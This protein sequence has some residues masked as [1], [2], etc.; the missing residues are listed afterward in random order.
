MLL[1]HYK[2]S[3]KIKALELLAKHNGLLQD[4]PTGNTTVQVMIGIA[5]P[6]TPANPVSAHALAVQTFAHSQPTIGETPHIP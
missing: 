2:G 4:A 3:D 6:G 1:E 5:P